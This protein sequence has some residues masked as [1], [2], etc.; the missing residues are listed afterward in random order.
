VLHDVLYFL[1]VFILNRPRS[2]P[3]RLFFVSV[4]AIRFAVVIAGIARALLAQ[5]LHCPQQLPDRGLKPGG[6]SLGEQLDP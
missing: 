2:P 3:S 4:R 6:I 5:L 1:C